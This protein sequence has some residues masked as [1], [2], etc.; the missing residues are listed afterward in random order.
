MNKI[1]VYIEQSDVQAVVYRNP[2]LQNLERD[3]MERALGEVRAAFLNEFG[4]EGKF[5]L[6]FRW[7]KV[8][9]PYVNGVRPVYKVV[10]A[11]AKTTAIL[12]RN[13]GWLARFSQGARL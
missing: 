5:N 6:Q 7:G 12:K 10:A 8:N 4:T 11:D 2:K 13:P 1:K 9:S 3:F